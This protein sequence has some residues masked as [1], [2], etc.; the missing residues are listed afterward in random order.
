MAV[1]VAD[2]PST[3]PEQITI[4]HNQ[5]TTRMAY[6]Q[7]TMSLTTSQS[8]PISFSNRPQLTTRPLQLAR[9][10]SI[11]DQLP[12][13]Q[14]DAPG[15]VP[16][17]VVQPSLTEGTADRLALNLTPLSIQPLSVRAVGNDRIVWYRT[18]QSD[19]APTDAK[20]TTSRTERRKA[21]VSAGIVAAAFNPELAVRSTT[22]PT[23][24]MAADAYP[25]QFNNLSIGAT[26][27]ISA[28]TGSALTVQVQTGL[29]LG[30]HWAVET[31]VGYLSGQASV[32]SPSRSNYAY[33]SSDASNATLYSDLINNRLSANSAAY[34]SVANS[35]N[36]P[37]SS[38][39]VSRYVTT[40][41]TVSNTYQF[42]QVPAQVSYEF[43]PRRKFGLALLTGLVS[44]WFV[45]NTIN[46]TVEVKAADGVY[47]PVTMAGT[48][49][50][51]LR[52]RP[53]AH[54]SASMAGSFQQN[55]QS[56]TLND[57]NLQALPQQVGLSF[58]VDR[59]F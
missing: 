52:Y 31:G 53:D 42:V 50:V 57:V 14:P 54:W 9:T 19:V 16:P 32:Q 51:R 28:R 26:P 1:R 45:R 30:E 20:T 17:T 25:N 36:D 39:K 18:E 41:Q 12:T 10:Q 46:Q 55:L 56:L 22:T 47:R 33:N 37:A 21:W 59:H 43:R 7:I 8:A 6:G 4:T 44:N 27:S 11:A 2:E 48:A 15:L 24:A 13:P 34:S 49:G 5:V 38:S 23:L 58:S 40:E 35:L 29:P 3:G